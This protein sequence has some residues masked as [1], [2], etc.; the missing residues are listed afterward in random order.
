MLSITGFARQCFCHHFWGQLTWDL[1]RTSEDGNF[2]NKALHQKAKEEANK[3]VF[4][5]WNCSDYILSIDVSYTYRSP[6]LTGV[7]EMD[8]PRLLQNAHLS[9]C[10]FAHGYLLCMELKRQSIQQF[11]I[12][13]YAPNNSKQ[14]LQEILVYTHVHSSIVYNSQMVTATQV[15]INRS[16]DKQSMVYTYRWILFSP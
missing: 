9:P 13:V 14:G 4:R 5:A 10:S 8:D 12:W 11:H 16:K 3:T 1:S 7:M 15:S 2:I 6:G